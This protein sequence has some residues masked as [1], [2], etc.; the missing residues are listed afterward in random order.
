MNVRSKLTVIM[1][2]CCFA[3]SSPA[4]EVSRPCTGNIETESA[5]VLTPGVS[6]QLVYDINGSRARI[7]FA[8]KTLEVDV[9]YGMDWKGPWLMKMDDSGY[10]SFRPEEGGDIKFQIE[11]DRWFSGSC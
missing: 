7:S 8:G 2:A 4:A 3:S 6:Y 1:F 9:E 10:F 11:P 5:R